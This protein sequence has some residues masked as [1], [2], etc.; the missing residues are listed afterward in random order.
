M[1]EPQSYKVLQRV[2]PTPGPPSWNGQQNKLPG[3]F[4]AGQ[5]HPGSRCY[6]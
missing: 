3:N 1:R 6:S 5:L 2:R 4:T